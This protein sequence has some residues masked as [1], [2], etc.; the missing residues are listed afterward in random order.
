VLIHKL[1]AIGAAALASTL[2]ASP[3]QAQEAYIGEMMLTAANFCPQGTLET[4]GQLLPIMQY[5]AL[6]S[7][8]GPTYGGDGRTT[9]AL[10][11]LAGPLPGTRYCIAV[12][13]NYPMR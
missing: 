7:L 9:F 4:Q 8:L 3:A 6:F 2:A 5:Q 11:K 12:Q 1:F 13:G 10:P